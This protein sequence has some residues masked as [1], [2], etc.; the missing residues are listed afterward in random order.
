MR[1]VNISAAG[2]EKYY[3]EKDPILNPDG[4]N[5]NTFFYGKG[6]EALG[7]EQN[8]KIGKEQFEKLCQGKH[9]RTGEQLIQSA[10]D[11]QAKTHHRAATDIPFSTPKSFSV[12]ALTYGKKD[13]IDIHNSAVKETM[14]RMEKEYSFARDSQG[15]PVYTGNSVFV[16][17]THATS[18][19]N[20]PQIHTHVLTMN[21]TKRPDG[22]F[23]ATHNDAIF[24]DQ[25]YITS[26]YR[27]ILSEKMLAA[28]YQL[29]SKGELIGIE[30]NLLENFSKRRVEIAKTEKE[31]LKKG[32]IKSDGLRNKKATL[33]SRPE[34]DSKI[35]AEQ[36]KEK[37]DAEIMKLEYTKEGLVKS[38]GE[39]QEKARVEKETQAPGEKLT[40]QDYVRFAVKDAIL[41]KSVF[42]KTEI[43]REAAKLSYK[44]GIGMDRLEKAFDALNAE[45]EIVTLRDHKSVQHKGVYST[46][47]QIQAEKEIVQMAKEGRGAVKAIMSKEEAEKAVK[48]YEVKKETV[49]TTGQKDAAIKVL[50]TTDRINLIAGHAGSGKT[51]AMDAVNAAVVA[52]DA[53]IS[54]RAMGFTGRAAAELEAKT[55]IS[56]TTVDRALID[57]KK[58]GVTH[59][60]KLWIIDEHS[61]LSSRKYHEI[62][63]LAVRDNA[64]IVSIGDLKQKSAIEAGKPVRDLQNHAGIQPSKMSEI[65]RQKPRWYREITTELSK[66]ENEKSIDQQKV[67]RAV[68]FAFSKLDQL[69]KIQEVKNDASLKKETV[70]EYLK[71]YKGTLIVTATNKDRSEYNS[72]IREK[73]KE[74][75]EV[76]QEGQRF[77]CFETKSLSDTDKRLAHN[78]EPGNY[79]SVNLGAKG[80]GVK[81]GIVAEITG[82]N[83]SKN[84]IDIKYENRYG[85]QKRTINVMRF[86]NNLSL[87][88]KKNIEFAS[89]DKILFL[90]N[91]TEAHK[92]EGI[93]VK[94]G[95]T[96]IVKSIGGEKIV[97]QVGQREISW[98]IRDYAYV[99]HGYAMTTDKA[100]GSTEGKVIMPSDTSK[101]GQHFRQFYT[102]ITRGERDVKIITTSKSELQE[103][104]KKI[105]EK[106]STLDYEK[107]KTKIER[108]AIS[109]MQKDL[110]PG[111]NK[112][113]YIEEKLVDK[114]P[115]VKN[116]IRDI[117][118][119]H[120][121]PNKTIEL[122]KKKEQALGA[123]DVGKANRMTEKI[124]K[125]VSKMT[126]E[127]KAKYRQFA[128]QLK[129]KNA[130]ALGP[131]PQIAQLDK[132]KSGKSQGADAGK[133][134]KTETQKSQSTGLEK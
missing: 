102:G 16:G 5:E 41:K 35:T 21:M 133:N 73:L 88:E 6:A 118:K 130:K 55:G 26:I 3:Y 117:E 31:L 56:A 106:S 25:K 70:K 48:D 90:K 36:L 131:E 69:G 63:R 85:K 10:I 61:M 67:N 92:R 132:S 11:P 108:K 47:E 28:G 122:L 18:R 119:N 29:D 82:R 74:K 14:D 65:L 93:N 13:I 59:N 103:S 27:S 80:M 127:Q 98:R 46:R 76:S 9:P 54:I 87:F 89:G 111:L 94:N 45:K 78:Y 40:A 66:V 50:T 57:L 113:G 42:T 115:L 71:N 95:Q 121:S 2:A 120:F 72:M 24:R 129:P 123:K 86:G 83:L 22:K 19:A 84:T 75:G 33:E 34:K 37:W 60:A 39:A 81:S 116:F 1:P 104:T 12:A 77:T 15:K 68:N 128:S 105:F 100:Q 96:G 99:S 23:V 43:L 79:I 51:T 30:K 17:A 97:A 58:D 7:L 134:Q 101:P 20:D 107:T 91:S 32:E 114:I 62:A 112:I 38:F 49:L 64:T 126:P 8:A 124:K 125:E 44:D 53:G 52:K 110:Y 4:K 109:K